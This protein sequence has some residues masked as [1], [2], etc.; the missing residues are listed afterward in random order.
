MHK[1]PV[2]IKV[3]A[4]IVCK[5]VLTH[6]C[7]TD[8]IGSNNIYIYIVLAL[9]RKSISIIIIMWWSG[10]DSQCTCTYVYEPSNET[11]DSFTLVYA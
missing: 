5:H 7:C 3:I 2:E 10:C 1:L 9:Q 8:L 6:R 4:L 11:H